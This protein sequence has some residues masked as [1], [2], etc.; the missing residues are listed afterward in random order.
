M[1]QG[2][3][4]IA[5]SIFAANLSRLGEQVAEAE[6]VERTASMWMSWTAISFRISRSVP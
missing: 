2:T 1:R 6:R 5:P 4:R 3:I